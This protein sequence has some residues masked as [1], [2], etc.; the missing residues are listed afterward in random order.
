MGRPYMYP[1]HAINYFRYK[2]PRAGARGWVP[3]YIRWVACVV[4]PELSRI[5]GIT[6][7]QQSFAEAPNAYTG[8]QEVKG[9]GGVAQL[10]G[11][12]MRGYIM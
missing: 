4:E 12:Q 8:H 10:G 3:V 9:G 2:D 6:Q 5:I 11:D 7:F 1:Q